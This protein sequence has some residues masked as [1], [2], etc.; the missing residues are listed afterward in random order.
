MEWNL[1]VETIIK[2]VKEDMVES[3]CTTY[4]ETGEMVDFNEL[5]DDN[6]SHVIQ[7]LTYEITLS[8]EKIVKA[9]RHEI[10]AILDIDDGD[11]I[12]DEIIAEGERNHEYSE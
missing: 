3:A 5:F 1:V 12:A 4:D 2:A 10:N 7:N 8:K 9:A 11:E 6:L